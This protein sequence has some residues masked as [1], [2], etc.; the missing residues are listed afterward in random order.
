[1]AKLGEYVVCVCCA[2]LL[3]GI[4]NAMMPKGTAKELLKLVG[5]LFLV[6]TI[7]Q[8]VQNVELPE[9]EDYGVRWQEEANEIIA[10]GEEMAR[11]AAI[12][13][14]KQELEAYILDKAQALRLEIRAQL[15]LN[16]ETLHPESLT[17]IG[18]GSPEAKNQLNSWIC[19][20]LGLT[21][22]DITWIS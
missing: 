19:R 7:I 1:M 2:A 9:A 21:Q 4:V 12:S 11:Q 6:F 13:S 17:I 10:R 20:E 22:E 5:G 16:E 18:K 15:K 8:P 14:I 3:C